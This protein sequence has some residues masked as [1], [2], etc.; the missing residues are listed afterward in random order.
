MLKK[1]VTNTASLPEKEKG[2]YEN[3]CAVNILGRGET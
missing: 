2:E 3:A 1:F